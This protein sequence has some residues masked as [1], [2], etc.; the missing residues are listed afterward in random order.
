MF[1]IF[2]CCIN[3]TCLKKSSVKCERLTK[4]ALLSRLMLFGCPVV[5]VSAE[6][7]AG[8]DFFF[9]V[10]ERGVVAVGDDGL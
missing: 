9:Y 2:L 1:A 4:K 3:T 6:N 5:S 10:I 7:I 8:I